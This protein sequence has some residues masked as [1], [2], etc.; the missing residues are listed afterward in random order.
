MF[1]H[2]FSFSFCHVL[3]KGQPW[4][5]SLYK[6]RFFSV[7]I[8]RYQTYKYDKSFYRKYGDKHEKL[9]LYVLF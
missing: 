7:S 4:R 2:Y 5:E 9:S 6:N 3:C 1:L 8:K